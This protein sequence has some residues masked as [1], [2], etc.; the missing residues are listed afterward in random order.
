MKESEP[1]IQLNT[2]P[3]KSTSRHLSLYYAPVEVL[4]NRA[5]TF[6]PVIGPNQKPQCSFCRGSWLTSL[7]AIV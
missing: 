5:E 6:L 1:F 7:V 3:S 4:A 2:S